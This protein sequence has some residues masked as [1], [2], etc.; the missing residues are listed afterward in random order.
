MFLNGEAISEPDPRGGRIIDAKFLLLF[1]AHSEP[2]TFTLPEASLASG[3]EVVIDTT[4]ARVPRRGVRTRPDAQDRG[5]GVRAGRS[6]CSVGGVMRLL[7]GQ[8]DL[9]DEDLAR[10]YAY[11]PGPW[12]RAN[13][14]ASVDGAANFDGASAGLSSDADR[15]VF[16]LLR[17]LADVIVV[18]AATVRAERYGPV[19][20][21]SCGA[22]CGPG[23]APTPP[24]AV[25]SARLDLDPASSLISSAPPHARTIVITTA[26][27]TRRSAAPHWTGTATSSWPGRTPST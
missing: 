15:H 16:A 26:A 22:T 23:R 19:R 2:I 6:S 20:P 9:T 8:S 13:F 18:G 3:W 10:L 11:P 7:A 25:V 21:A 12:L 24:I 17:T 4:T 1:N 14:V 5:R 27:V